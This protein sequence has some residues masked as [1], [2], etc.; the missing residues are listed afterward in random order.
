MTK[1]RN[2]V[3]NGSTK[4]TMGSGMPAPP[5][6]RATVKTTAPV[7][8]TGSARRAVVQTPAPPSASV[9]QAIK[10]TIP[11]AT[12]ETNGH[13]TRQITINDLTPRQTEV[14]HRLWR[15]LVADG[16][17]M[18]NGRLVSNQHQYDAIRWL[19]DKIADEAGLP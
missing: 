17:V 12:S 15:R 1:D 2:G 14:Y 10:L 13:R 18:M 3:A 11:L 5:A 4:T 16:T 19:L 8:E 7:P 9:G 6:A